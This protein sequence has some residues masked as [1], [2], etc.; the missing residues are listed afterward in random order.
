MV[1]ALLVIVL[2]VRPR[3]LLGSRAADDHAGD[4]SL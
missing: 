3:G 1:F 2:T 4:L